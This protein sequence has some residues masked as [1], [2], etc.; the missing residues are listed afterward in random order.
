MIQQLSLEWLNSE[1]QIPQAL[2]DTCFPAP[3]E[4]Q[5]WY[6][7]LECA[8]LEEQ[9]T[10][11]YGLISL[12][13]EPIAIAPAFVK[14]VPIELVMP[15]MILPIVKLISKI[16]PSFLYQR[17]FFIGSAGSDEGHIGIDPKI[18]KAQTVTQDDIFLCVQEAAE[19]QAQKYKAAMLVWKDFPNIYH[20]TLATISKS[21]KLFPLISFPSALVTLEG[22]NTDDYI[23]SLKSSRRDQFLKKLKKALPAPLDVSIVHLPDNQTLHQLY[24]LFSRTYSK[25]KTKF[26]ELTPEFFEFISREKEAHFIVL[27]HQSSQEIVAFMLCFDLKGHVI[28]KFIGIDYD[29]PRDWFI[30]F[31]L[32]IEAVNWSYKIGAKTIQSGQTAYPAK[33][34][35]G[36]ELINLTNFCKHRN[37]FMHEICKKVASLVNWDTLDPDLAVYLKAYPEE[38]PDIQLMKE[39]M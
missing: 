28:N 10:F 8:H 16:I 20:Q 34:E 39:E 25:G 36:H 3:Y 24:R 5:W 14:D 6:R 27:R 38:K 18:L 31:R 9:F 21:K 7:S 1:S 4:G 22:G 17:T 30:Y 15:P 19:K 32:W 12:N 37:R 26:E 2:W 11:T 23:N 33:I 13:G 29:A 35:T